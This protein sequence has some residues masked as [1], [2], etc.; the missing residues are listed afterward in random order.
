MKYS[1]GPCVLFGS[2]KHTKTLTCI[3]FEAIYILTQG[4]VLSFKPIYLLKPEPKLKLLDITQ[5]PVLSLNFTYSSLLV[6]KTCSK[7]KAT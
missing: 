4:P 6:T 3:R 1:S 7:D 5:G 2:F